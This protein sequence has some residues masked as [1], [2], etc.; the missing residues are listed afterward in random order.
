MLRSIPDM[1]GSAM[2]RRA[3]TLAGL[4]ALLLQGS[5]GT[6]MLLVEH[7]RCTEHGELVHGGEAHQHEGAAHVETGSGAFQTGSDDGSD[8]GHGHC[9]LT[10]DRRGALLS[11]AAARVS[12]RLVQLRQAF[13]PASTCVPVDAERFRVAPKN[14]PPA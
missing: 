8:E 12:P 9:A 1:R 5:S 3:C 14:S 7:S 6:H 2:I 13:G 10:V 4:L 11:I